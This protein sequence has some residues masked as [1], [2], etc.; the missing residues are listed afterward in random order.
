MRSTFKVLFFLKRDKQKTNGMI[1]LFCRITV[2]GQEARFGMK[3]DVNPK[4]WD[5]K[6]GRA[7]G[8]TA[9]SVKINALADNTKS[10]IFGIYRELQE[11]DNYV[12]AEKVK[13]VFLGIEIRQQ[14]LLEFFDVYI[15]ELQVTARTTFSHNNYLYGLT[16]RL[17]ADFLRLWHN[18]SDIAVREIEP[19]FI[20][21]FE[22]YLAANY[23][24]AHNTT[25]KHLKNLKHVMNVA[26]ERDFIGKNPFAKFN[27]QYKNPGREILTQEEIETL[28]TFKFEDK[29]LERTRD[30]FVFCCFTGLSYIDVFNMSSENLQPAFDGSM[31]I[32]GR[33]KKTDTEY[34]IPLLN[35]PKMILDKYE[36]RLS[37][38]RLLPITCLC[39]YNLLLKKTA[40]TCGIEKNLSSHIARHTFATTITLTKGVPIETV[41]K[42]LGHTSIQTTQIYAKVINSKISSDMALLA[43]KLGDME[44]KMAVNF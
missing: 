43:E 31:W 24:Y 23:N 17:L 7:S 28:M 13:N 35:I 40:Q 25:A 1:P 11:R 20:H 30:I 29:K 12:T 5:V 21:D 4:F 18:V 32:K 37:G 38:N 16:R 3:C 10:A 9:E 19:K 14:T 36:N 27:R 22:A 39:Q 34:S 41:S 26:V 44:T 42:M 33:R 8:R 6:T 2:D 15:K